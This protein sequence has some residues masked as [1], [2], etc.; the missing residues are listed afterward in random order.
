MMEV[1]KKLRDQHIRIVILF[2]IVL[3]KIK[4]L[5]NCELATFEEKFPYMIAFYIAKMMK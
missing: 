3:K 2:I 5:L 1:H 4:T